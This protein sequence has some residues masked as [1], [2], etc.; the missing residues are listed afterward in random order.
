MWTFVCFCSVQIPSQSTRKWPWVQ[1][2]EQTSVYDEYSLIWF[3]KHFFDLVI[4]KSRYI[5]FCGCV[6]SLMWLSFSIQRAFKHW[7]WG[8]S[9][10]NNW[11]LKYQPS[12]ASL[13]DI[14]VSLIWF[15]KSWS[16]L[17]WLY[18]YVDCVYILWCLIPCCNCYCVS[19]IKV[20]ISSVL[21]SYSRIT[22]L[23][24]RL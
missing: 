18:Q 19:E 12:T 7:P 8:I 2:R 10:A 4:L 15:P 14:C 1:S 3:S 5:T 6:I 21:F 20:I 24:H 13:H 23:P 22:F 17:C 9:I 11:H 16:Q